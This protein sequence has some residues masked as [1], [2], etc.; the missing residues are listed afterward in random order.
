MTVY[1]CRDCG[2]LHGAVVQTCGMCGSGNV[3]SDA[4]PEPPTEAQQ[5]KDS[6]LRDEEFRAGV[7][8]LVMAAFH[9]FDAGAAWFSANTPEIEELDEDEDEA[10]HHASVGGG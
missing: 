2:N 1:K 7:K 6:L 8:S 10:P 3:A 4:P 9:F 5:L